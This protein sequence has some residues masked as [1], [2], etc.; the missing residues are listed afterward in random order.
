M[1]LKNIINA[2][3]SKDISRKTRPALATKQQNGEFIG[4]WAAYGYQKCADD[5]HRIEPDEET[6]PV[7]WDIFQWRLSCLSYQNIA[8]KLN[9]RG[10]PSPSRYHY[11]KGDATSE[12]YANTLWTI[13]SIKNILTSEVYLGHMV[14]GRKRSG[15]SEGKKPYQVPESEWVIVRNTHEPL[16]DED[17]FLKV[18]RMAKEAS[19]TYKERLG[20]HDGLGTI[21]NIFRGLVYCADCKQTMTRYKNV[22]KKGTQLYYTYI[23]R[24]HAK[25]PASCP[26]KNLHETELKEIL[27]DAL[28]REIAL[29]ENLDKLVRQYNQSAKAVSRENAVKREITAVKQALDRATMLYDS[30][31][32]NYVAKLMTE[33]EYAEMKQKYRSDMDRAKARLETLEQQQKE[34]RHQTT[35]NPW[36]T[37]CIQYQQETELTEAMAHALIER[38]EV[39]AQ[40]RVSITLRYQDEYRALLQLMAA[41]GE[42]V[43][44]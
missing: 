32:Q 20:R 8:R 38:V 36:L 27:W 1:P 39:D 33:Q 9:E 5:R 13:D 11:L 23:C 16:I 17:T 31:Y 12:R 3:Y 18:Q 2:V 19:S 6:A 35:E 29:A 34:S 41:E 26:N 28:R 7:V 10:I 14:Q 15:F 30:L 22:T 37:A 40:N 43:S 44:E 42:A 4:T 24:T 25:N 21:P